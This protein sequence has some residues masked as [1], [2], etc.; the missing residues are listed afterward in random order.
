MDEP[1]SDFD[2]DGYKDVLCDN[3][4]GYSS[5]IF[6]VYKNL[7]NN[8]FQKLSD[9][10]FQ[11]MCGPFN[12]AD[13]NNDG[14]PDVIWPKEDLTGYIIWYNQGN[15]QLADSQFVSVPFTNGGVS[16]SFYCADLDNNGFNDIVTVRYSIYRIHNV[17]INTLV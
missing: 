17:D 8:T 5:T 3:A 14:L 2:G 13:F 15:F 6:F 7:G 9:F 12:V 1:I 4:L 10:I 16:R 11:P